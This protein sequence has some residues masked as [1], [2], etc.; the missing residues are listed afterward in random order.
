[1]G[2]TLQQSRQHSHGTQVYFS[3]IFFQRVAFNDNIITKKV[4][5]ES[6]PQGKIK[7]CARSQFGVGSPS[8]ICELKRA[9]LNRVLKQ[10]RFP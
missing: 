9:S 10:F 4:I 3:S 6:P 1:M 5:E 7:T 2:A 8:R